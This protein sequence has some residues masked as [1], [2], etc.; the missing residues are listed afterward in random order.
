ME[1]NNGKGIFYGVIGVATLIVAIIGATFAYFTATTQS[2]QYVTGTAA[3]ASLAVSVQRMTGYSLGEGAESATAA[4]FT[5]VPQLDKGLSQA[6]VGTTV[7]GVNGAGAWGTKIEGGSTSTTPHNTA[8]IDDNGSLVCSIY[9][10]T[11]QNTGSAAIDINGKIEF[12]GTATDSLTANG[13]DNTAVTP[14][15]SLLNHLKWARLADPTTLTGLTTNEQLVANTSMPSTL[16]TYGADAYYTYKDGAELKYAAAG[17]NQ[18]L[19]AMNITDK[20]NNKDLLGVDKTV[21]TGN[22]GAYTDLIDPTDDLLAGSNYAANGS[23]TQGSYHL[24]ANGQAGDTKVYYIVV[25]ISENEQQ[26]NADDFGT[27]TGQVTF[28]SAGGSGA[29]STFTEAYSGV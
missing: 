4:K 16:L 18:Y 5:M 17:A 29:T 23:A 22:H 27:F 24:E 14:G 12:Y 7:D 19:F 10:I 26:Q 20:P 3:T 2:G 9:K 11:V 8:C 13:E 1:N 6:I 15:D 21:V 28:N 25:W